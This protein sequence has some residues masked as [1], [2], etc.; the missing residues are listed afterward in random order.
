LPTPRPVSR[1]VTLPKPKKMNY[2]APE[3]V[4]VEFSGEAESDLGIDWGA[5]L[6][7]LVAMIAVLGLLPFWVYIF[8]MYN[9]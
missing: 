6:L 1:P 4:S 3:Q 7:G 5:V 9:R 2:A 8:Q